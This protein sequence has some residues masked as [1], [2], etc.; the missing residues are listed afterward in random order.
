MFHCYVSLP[1]G[2]STK[3]TTA[4]TRLILESCYFTNFP[5]FHLAKVSLICQYVTNLDFPEIRGIAAFP[6]QKGYLFGAKSVMWGRDNLTR[7]HVCNWASE[8]KNLI[9]REKH[10]FPQVF[11]AEEKKPA[12]RKA[13]EKASS[14]IPPTLGGV[15]PQAGPLLVTTWG[16]HHNSTSFRGWNNTRHSH[17]YT[18]RPMS[19]H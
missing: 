7:L 6:F 17:W 12:C 3:Q 5:Y 2:T 16:G 15:E 19:L 4:T 11:S 1:E 8:T 9:P 14:K 18:R 13:S 10:P